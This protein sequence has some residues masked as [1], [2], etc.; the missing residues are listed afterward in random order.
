MTENEYIETSQ[1]MTEEI[2]CHLNNTLQLLYKNYGTE[3][4]NICFSSALALAVGNSLSSYCIQNKFD[5]L[6]RKEII[7]SFNNTMKWAANKHKEW[8]LKET[9]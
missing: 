6:K 1:L 5:R 9:H 4:T 8:K 7:G 3:K 2:V